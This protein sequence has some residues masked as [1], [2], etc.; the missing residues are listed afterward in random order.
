MLVTVQSIRL[1]LLLKYHLPFSYHIHHSSFFSSEDGM[2]GAAGY[3]DLPC[4]SNVQ[5][6]NVL[7]INVKMVDRL[8]STCLS[9]IHR[10]ASKS[11]LPKDPPILRS[12]SLSVAQNSSR[13]LPLES[14][15]QPAVSLA[16]HRSPMPL[17]ADIHLVLGRPSILDLA[18]GGLSR[19]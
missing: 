14:P 8:V 17:A 5:T 19:S 3:S 6:S 7:K 11:F 15:S 1:Y 2:L 13:S 16:T 4:V 10:G 9:E 18:L 12:S